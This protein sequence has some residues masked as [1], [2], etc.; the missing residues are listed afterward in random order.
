[1]SVLEEL[2]TVELC[3]TC[4]RKNSG[5][6]CPR[7]SR[8]I[9]RTM[10]LSFGVQIADAEARLGDTKAF[11]GQM[12]NRRNR[13]FLDAITE[14]RQQTRVFL[15]R[16]GDFLGVDIDEQWKAMSADELLDEEIANWRG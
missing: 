10:L 7:C 9:D 4:K 11:V 5:G 2:W 8:E 16:L 14:Y 6:L 1:M 15:K 13:Q 12:A 3:R